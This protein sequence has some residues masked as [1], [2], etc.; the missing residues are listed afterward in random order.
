V[1]VGQWLA[2]DFEQQVVLPEAERQGDD[3]DEDAD[4][5]PVA[6]LVEVLDGAE[7]VLVG[8]RPDAADGGLRSLGPFVVGGAGGGRLLTLA[9]GNRA[10]E[11]ADAAA[12]AAAE[13]REPFRAE[14]HQG[15]D[16][17]DRDLEWAD[18]SWHSLL[19]SQGGHPG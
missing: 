8:D 3:E 9:A 15:D 11:L 16:E 7:P 13:L 19:R 10:F 4:D 12:D 1:V 6:Q 17:D 5:Q 14:H 18:V 2:G